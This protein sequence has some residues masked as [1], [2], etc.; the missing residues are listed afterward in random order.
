MFAPCAS[1]RAVTPLRVSP[2]RVR[3]H[4]PDHVR[5]EPAPGVRPLRLPADPA[6]LRAAGAG[7]EGLRRGAGRA[8]H[9]AGDVRLLPPEGRPGTGSNLA[10]LK[11]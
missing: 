3:E 4:Q 2:E 8:Q 7:V 5:R 11:N 10:P 6:D 1:A 9:P